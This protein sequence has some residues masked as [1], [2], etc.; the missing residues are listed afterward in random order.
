M[1][2]NGLAARLG[3]RGAARPRP[4]RSPPAEAGGVSYE[5]SGGRNNRVLPSIV[6]RGLRV[7]GRTPP[8]LVQGI[9]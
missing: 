6:W 9:R 2:D 3:V 4:L 1:G 7:S 5:R 8:V